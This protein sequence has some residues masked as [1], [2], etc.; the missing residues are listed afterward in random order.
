MIRLITHKMF[1]GNIEVTMQEEM[2]NN[3]H[4]M[5]LGNIEV[6]NLTQGNIEVT[7]QEKMEQEARADPKA[8]AGG[9]SSDYQV[10]PSHRLGFSN[11]L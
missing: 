1:P 2:E 10:L 4:K 11:T 7:I 6:T 9:M 3:R 8:L 5:I